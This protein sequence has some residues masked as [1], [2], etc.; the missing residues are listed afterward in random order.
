M[1]YEYFD[2][3][4]PF[5]IILTTVHVIFTFSFEKFTLICLGKYNMQFFSLH[6]DKIDL[7]LSYKNI[8]LFKKHI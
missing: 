2:R 4:S 3:K 1:N 8:Y 7:I 5:L 6:I